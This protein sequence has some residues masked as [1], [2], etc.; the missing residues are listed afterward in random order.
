[1]LRMIAAALGE[2]SAAALLTPHPLLLPQLSHNLRPIFIP[3]FATYYIS[4]AEQRIHMRP[5]PVHP[6]AFH[7][8]FDHQLVAAFHAATPNRIARRLEAGIL[9]VRTPGFQILNRSTDLV[10]RFGRG[11]APLQ[12]LLERV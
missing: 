8:R 5:R 7:P 1:M 9:N 10:Q 12:L 6:R 11:T 3:P 2:P 4:Q